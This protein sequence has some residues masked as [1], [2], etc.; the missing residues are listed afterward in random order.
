[1]LKASAAGYLLLLAWLHFQACF[2]GLLSPPGAEARST[3]FVSTISQPSR[4]VKDQEGRLRGIRSEFTTDFVLGILIPVYNS[5]ANSSGGR[6]GDALTDSG[7]SRVDT[8]L[9]ALDCINSDPDLL[10]NVTLG[11]DIRDTCSSQNIALDETL[12]ILVAESEIRTGK[13]FFQH[14]WK[15]RA[16]KP[17]G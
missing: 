7:V 14:P 15:C 9:Y 13:L 5:A 17:H 8:I 1:M 12:D 2:I 16:E 3:Q 11:Y 10:P 6:C 4:L